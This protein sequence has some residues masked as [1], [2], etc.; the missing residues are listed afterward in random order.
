MLKQPYVY[1]KSLY[2]HVINFNFLVNNTG[3]RMK[4]RKGV[5]KEWKKERV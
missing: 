2:F 1:K 5:K 3:E 4:K